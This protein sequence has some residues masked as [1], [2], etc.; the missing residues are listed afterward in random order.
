MGTIGRYFLKKTVGDGG[1]GVAW[2]ACDEQGETVCVKVFK[3]LD[4]NAKESFDDETEVLVK[5]LYHPNV[6]R[7]L[8]AGSD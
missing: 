8:A 2:S 5:K 6:V 7:Y 3:F 4:K 1:Y